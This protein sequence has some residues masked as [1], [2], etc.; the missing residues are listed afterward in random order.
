MTQLSQNNKQA[1]TEINEQLL[2][3]PTM[4]LASGAMTAHEKAE[5]LQRIVGGLINVL[6]REN[7]LII[8]KPLLNLQGL[9]EIAT[10]KQAL[11]EEYHQFI[12]SIGSVKAMANEMSDNVK[13]RLKKLF[14]NYEDVAQI[15]ERRLTI[16]A[17]ISS[18]ILDA[19]SSAQADATSTLSYN[20][21]GVIK[22]SATEP[23][24]IRKE[25]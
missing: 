17:Q 11:F 10:Q 20:Q 13:L 6:D 25:I 14:K 21:H 24:G 23:L 7:D 15:N 9:K 3:T 1:A 2:D 4:T 5:E 19:V 22:R 12:S 8:Q 16:A 18:R